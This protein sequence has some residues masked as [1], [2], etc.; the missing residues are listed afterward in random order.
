MILLL[1]LPPLTAVTAE[2]Q[3]RKEHFHEHQCRACTSKCNFPSPFRGLHLMTP[4]IIPLEHDQT[5]DC[6]KEMP[7]FEADTAG[8]RCEAP[9]HGC[10]RASSSSGLAEHPGSFLTLHHRKTRLHLCTHLNAD[11]AM[12][13]FRRSPAVTNLGLHL[14]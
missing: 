6:R 1:M 10:E 11:R 7:C 9:H 14:P 2:A 3:D 12:V 8:L 5:L 4:V 13:C